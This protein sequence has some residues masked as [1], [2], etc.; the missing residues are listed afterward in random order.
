MG[1]LGPARGVRQGIDPGPDALDK[2]DCG[3]LFTDT[4]GGAKAE[5][6]GLD[7][8]LSFLRPGDT[9]IVWRLDRIGRSLQHPIET[10]GRLRERGIG[11]RS[12]SESIDTTSSS[13]RLF[14]LSTGTPLT[15]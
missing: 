4:I 10:V 13:G 6:L 12:I 5:R 15:S 7:D 8:A 3:R 1:R 9:L 2:V 11:F 14:G